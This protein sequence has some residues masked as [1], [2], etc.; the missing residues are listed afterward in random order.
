MPENTYFVLRSQCGE[1]KRTSREGSETGSPR[2]PA[3]LHP[4]SQL[5]MRTIEQGGTPGLEARKILYHFP[6][7]LWGKVAWNCRREVL[8]LGLWSDFGKAITSSIVIKIV[9]FSQLVS[10][11][12]RPYEWDYTFPFLSSVLMSPHCYG[13]PIIIFLQKGRKNVS[14]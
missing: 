5:H 3:E 1:D 11:G 4:S 6:P 9:S 7:L 12:E 13:Y 8:Y 2:S 10:P 14:F